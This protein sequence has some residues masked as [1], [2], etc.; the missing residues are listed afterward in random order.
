VED[1]CY[2]AAQK[3]LT[4]NSKWPEFK[5]IFELVATAKAAGK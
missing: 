5:I 3:R 2:D 4:E 1:K